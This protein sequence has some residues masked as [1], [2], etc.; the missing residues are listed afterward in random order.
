LANDR[1]S[2]KRPK[3]KHNTNTKHSIYS[4][5]QTAVLGT[6]HILRNVLQCE[7]GVL[8]GWGSCWFRERGNGERRAVTGDNII[9]IV[10]LII[11]RI[12]SAT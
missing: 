1:K 6:S 9:I 2:K 11:R 5:K 4:V 3:Y 12:K 8:S 7:T 10:I